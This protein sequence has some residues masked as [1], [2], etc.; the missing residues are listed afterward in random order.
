M[1][2]TIKRKRERDVIFAQNASIIFFYFVVVYKKD[3]EAQIREE[4]HFDT[5][6]KKVGTT[7]NKFY[8]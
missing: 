4:A 7:R 8:V 2:F 5:I 6:K 3:V 1:F